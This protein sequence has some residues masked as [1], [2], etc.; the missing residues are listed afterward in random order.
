MNDKPFPF[1]ETSL[2]GLESRSF[3]IPAAQT[4]GLCG[5]YVSPSNTEGFLPFVKTAD[6]Q[7]KTFP[8]FGPQKQKQGN[9]T[10]STYRYLNGSLAST[11]VTGTDANRSAS[12]GARYF[13]PASSLRSC[14][15]VS[16]A[17]LNPI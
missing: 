6:I 5:G 8:C 10:K 2:Q 11:N 13:I 14:P 1:E 3:N 12:H 17:R 9:A 7:I 4:T 16:I 15:S